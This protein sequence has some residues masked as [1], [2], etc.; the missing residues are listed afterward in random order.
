MKVIIIT[1]NRVPHRAIQISAY[2]DPVGTLEEIYVNSTGKE[3]FENS[4]FDGGEFDNN[5]PFNWKGKRGE[6]FAATLLPL[7]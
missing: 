7:E 2:A 6:V 5:K 1:K 3:L 4:S